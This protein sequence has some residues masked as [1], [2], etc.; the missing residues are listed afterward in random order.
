MGLCL[1]TEGLNHGNSFHSQRTRNVSQIAL[2]MLRCCGGK[3]RAIDAES[4]RPP[5]F[6][7]GPAF[8]SVLCI[9]RSVVGLA[10]KVRSRDPDTLVCVDGKIGVPEMASNENLQH[11]RRADSQE[12]GRAL[13]ANKHAGGWTFPRE[14]GLTRESC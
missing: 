4:V 6:L 13:G 5:C 10:R 3:P 2:R 12:E 7:T 9:R 14:G 8:N 11:P 1:S